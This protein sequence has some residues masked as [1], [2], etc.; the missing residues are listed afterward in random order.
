MVEECAKHEL[1]LFEAKKIQYS[2]LKTDQIIL[3]PLASIEK[4]NIIHLHQGY[5]D[6]LKAL[7]EAYVVFKVKMNH[8]DADNAPV[9]TKIAT[10]DK[11]TCSIANNTLHS[12]IRQVNV[13]LNGKEI[14]KNSNNYHRSYIEN[15]LTHDN[16]TSG[17]HLDGVIFKLDVAKHFDDLAGSN[18]ASGDRG[19]LFQPN[20]PVELVGR[21]HLEMFSCQKLLLNN[22]DIGI[23]IELNNPDFFMRKVAPDNKSS[24]ELLDATLYL[25]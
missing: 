17:R 20:H 14:S 3:K 1:K 23:S 18:T 10:H 13:T 24:L 19:L 22:I 6:E 4:S 12:L 5:S 8:F 11:L 16:Q 2:I 21:L 9:T 25:D 7:T 15:L